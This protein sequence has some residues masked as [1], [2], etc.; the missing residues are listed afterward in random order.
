M[1]ST[2]HEC[3]RSAVLELTATLTIGFAIFRL[4]WTTAANHL[5]PFDSVAVGTHANLR[6]RLVV[7]TWVHSIYHHVIS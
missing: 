5:F 6:A 4:G 7:E 1:C 2:M 3:H